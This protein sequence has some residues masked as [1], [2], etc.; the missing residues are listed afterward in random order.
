MAG[1]SRGGSQAQQVDQCG[2]R[3]GAGSL[4]ETRCFQ[5]YAHVYLFESHAEI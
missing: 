2:P 5:H 1:E 3:E 4:W